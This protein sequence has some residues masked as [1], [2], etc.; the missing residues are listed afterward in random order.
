MPTYTLEQ[1]ADEGPQFAMAMLIKCIENGEPFVTYGAICNELEYQLEIEKIFPTQI[2]RVA[3]TL[4]SSILEIEPDAPLINV[5]ITRPNGIPGV[6]VS[7]Y[8][9]ERYN[10]NAL[11]D[12]DNVAIN[13]RK[14][15]GLFGNLR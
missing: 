7:E 8:I 4:M 5:L 1:L 2:G 12:W 6:G 15:I 11:R 3:G 9:A 14:K 13:E 10:N